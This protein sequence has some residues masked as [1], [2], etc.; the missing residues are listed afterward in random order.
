[1]NWF[2][3]ASIITIITGLIAF[4]FKKALKDINNAH[5]AIKSLRKEHDKNT[6]NIKF[7]QGKIL[8]IK[9][10]AEEKGWSFEDINWD[11]E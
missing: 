2:E 5:T 11:L 3:V 4:I 1:M 9:N 10:Q 8:T 6:R 7:L